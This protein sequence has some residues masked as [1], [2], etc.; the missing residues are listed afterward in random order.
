MANIVTMYSLV[1]MECKKMQ[2]QASCPRNK[3]SLRWG[4]KKTQA[5]SVSNLEHL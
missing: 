2:N 1:T 4:Y 3:N 5:V